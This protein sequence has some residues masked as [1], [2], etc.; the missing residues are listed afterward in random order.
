[1]MPR[2]VTLLLLALHAPALSATAQSGGF[3]VRLGN[4]TMHVERFERVGDRI[5]GTIA[6]RAPASRLSHDVLTLDPTGRVRHFEMRSNTGDGQPRPRPP[7][8]GS[9][10]YLADSVVRSVDRDS[11]GPPVLRIAAPRP[12]FPGPWIPYTGMTF[13]AYELTLNEARADAVNGEGP[14]RCSRYSCTASSAWRWPRTWSV[15]RSGGAR[16]GA[17]WCHGARSGDS[18]PTSP[19]MCPSLVMCASATCRYPPARTRSGCSR[20][21][22]EARS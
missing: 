7:R 22:L 14:S 18:V 9:F 21:G 10:E 1:M 13:L 17:A 5:T 6:S 12:V 15:S 3:V 8:I 2:S 11:G 16:S 4:D 19:H 20:R